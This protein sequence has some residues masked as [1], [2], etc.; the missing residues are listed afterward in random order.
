MIEGRVTDLCLR[1]PFLEVREEIDAAAGYEIGLMAWSVVN[2][3]LA[4]L[5]VFDRWI[6][7]RKKSFH[8]RM[9]NV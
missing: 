2:V 7:Q 5:L 4:D 8:L 9:M 1:L 3:R 6:V